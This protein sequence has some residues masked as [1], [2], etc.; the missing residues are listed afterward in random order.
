MKPVCHSLPSR[1]SSH[2]YRAHVLQLLKHTH[3]RAHDLK[4][5]KPKQWKSCALQLESSPWSLQLE[6]SPHSKKDSVWSKIINKSLK[7]LILALP[8]SYE[9]ISNGNYKKKKMGIPDH[10]TCLLRNLYTDQ[11]ATVRT[12][13]GKND[14]LKLGKEYN[15]TVYFH[16]A[17]LTYTEYLR[18]NVRLE[19]SQAGIEHVR[20]YINNL[21]YADNTTLMAESDDDSERREWKSWLETQHLK[22]KIRSSDPIISWQLERGKV[23]AVTNFIFSDS[24]IT[25]DRNWSHEIMWE[26]YDRPRKC[27]KKQRYHFAN[28]AL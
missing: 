21:W 11:E 15:K 16:P 22:T 17:C 23:E 1:A 10:L 13:H 12:G 25:V 18:W 9:I 7:K 8:R 26:S 5:E 19:E 3:T 2:N 20:A 4:E 6:K 24:K 27:I 14:W 28:K